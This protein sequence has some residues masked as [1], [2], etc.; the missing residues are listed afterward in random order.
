MGSGSAGRSA[1]PDAREHLHTATTRSTRSAADSF[2]E[3]A[4]PELFASGETVRKRR[5]D[6]RDQ[7]TPGG[8]IARLALA[9]RTNQEIGCELSI[10]PHNV[11][12]HP[13]SVFTK[14][15]IG[16]RKRLDHAAYRLAR[17]PVA[18]A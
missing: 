12:W 10:S 1:A 2:A 14:R 17:M 5:D 15:G 16:S 11:A 3:R 6:T 7:L 13:K 9:G 18:A 8:A 4:R